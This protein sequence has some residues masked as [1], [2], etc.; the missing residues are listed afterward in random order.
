MIGV[1][2]ICLHLLFGAPSISVILPVYNR[3][4]TLVP[5]LE[6]ILNQTLKSIEIVCIDD[7]SKDNTYQVARQYADKYENIL[8]LKNDKNRGLN[9]TLNYCLSCAQGEYIARQDGDDVSLPIRFEREINLL[10][11]DKSITFVSSA[12]IHFNENG[13]YK[14]SK[15]ISSPKKKDFVRNSPFNHPAC[16]IRR[17][18]LLDVGGYS[19]SR[20]LLRVEDYHLWFKLY[21]KGYVGFNIKD[22]LYKWRDDTMAYKRRTLGNRLNEIYVR[23]IGYRMLK[24]PFYYYIFCF[25]P[26]VVW[27][28]PRFIYDYFRN[29]SKN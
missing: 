23:F 20:R 13:D 15:V 26:I 6:S 27:L 9:Y 25:R 11:S 10:K 28:L 21:A 1:F 16:M 17:T 29:K 4:K 5:C 24:L 22:P 2:A 3:E 8:L 7:G 12:V 18:A 19:E 14:I